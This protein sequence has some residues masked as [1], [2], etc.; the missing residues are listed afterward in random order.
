MIS[1]LILTL[2]LLQVVLSCPGSESSSGH[3][4]TAE[5]LAEIHRL[6]AEVTD[7]NQAVEDTSNTIE[8]FGVAG[9]PPNGPLFPGTCA[10]G[11]LVQNA[12]NT[13]AVMTGLRKD[14]YDIIKAIIA[15]A[16][17]NDNVIKTAPGTAKKTGI[18]DLVGK[19]YRVANLLGSAAR[20][21]FHDAGEFD[22]NSSDNFGP[23]G[24]LSDSDPNSGLKEDVTITMTLI[25][26][27]YTKYCDKMSRADF[28]VLFGKIALE[29]AL[30][31]GLFAQVSGLPNLL[32][33]GQNSKTQL[34]L[35]FQWG[36]KD[37]TGSCDLPAGVQRLPA[38]QP[39]LSEFIK[40]FVTNMG[41]TLTD[42]VVLSGAHSVGH[43]HTQFSG[44]GHGDSLATLESNPLTNAWDES[45]FIFD[46][47]YYD[48]LAGEFW[49][50]NDFQADVIGTD[51]KGTTATGNAAKNKGSNFWAVQVVSGAPQP[52]PQCE[53]DATCGLTINNDIF[54][55]TPNGVTRTSTG[56][57]QNYAQLIQYQTPN[58]I[59]NACNCVQFFALV[60]NPLPANCLMGE[61]P[62]TIMLNADMAQNFPITTPVAS[63][64]FKGK[65]D[66]LCAP[67]VTA[68]PKK[69]GGDII[70]PQQFIN[71][72][73]ATVLQGFGCV[74]NSKGNLKKNN[75]QTVNSDSL[76][77][78]PT[79]LSIS[80]WATVQY[81][82]TFG[83]A[84]TCV[85]GISLK[86]P[87]CYT[88]GANVGT[89]VKPL[90]SG[91]FIGQNAF[92]SPPISTTCQL[93]TLTKG[94]GR[95]KFYRAFELAWQ[96]MVTVGYSVGG[97]PLYTGAS[98]KL[99]N[100]NK[101]TFPAPISST[102]AGSTACIPNTGDIC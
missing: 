70:F 59:N 66:E 86:Y 27:L 91:G 37:A 43:V 84:D 57:N 2:A 81:F 82:M 52:V 68:K 41:L 94:R 80:L 28:W 102:P 50:N 32:V 46:N 92:S 76:V 85:N 61:H 34:N 44:F 58:N 45:P 73:G 25:Q 63:S 5:D 48:S 23:D 3:L 24:C 83:V 35:P 69:S 79:S 75:V 62:K 49:L 4:R 21:V 42:G 38:H 17:S 54:C 98:T 26:G 11:T 31:N 8:S 9:I 74:T 19:E 40:T 33:A 1:K 30:P 56:G 90:N 67:F 97:K 20:L 51:L 87:A 88:C 101:I 72:N 64:G 12:A 22:Q 65:I 96:K 18:I 16:A 60:K 39:G 78:D 53:L 6:L 10:K 29:S 77:S 99:G 71:D 95:D 93:A 89:V 14:F 100:L 7:V 55:V 36:R 15:G 13:L 47:L